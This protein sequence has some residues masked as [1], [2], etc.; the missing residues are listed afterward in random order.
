[1][2]RLIWVGVGVTGTVLVLRQVAKANEAFAP[3]AKWT[4]PAR[5]T[6]S[7]TSLAVAARE[8]GEQVRTA[9]AEN[10]A[11]LTAALLPDED[12]VNRARAR[13]AS[14]S[15]SPGDPF[16]AQPDFELGWPDEPDEPQH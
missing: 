6:E 14:S 11:T 10:E 2:K 1:M 3:I 8:L 12:T 15:S 5:L 16:A 4:S 9:M 13:R 7:V